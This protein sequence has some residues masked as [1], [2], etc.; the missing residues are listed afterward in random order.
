MKKSKSGEKAGEAAAC[1][2]AELAGLRSVLRDVGG[3]FMANLEA[4]IVQL[5][6][7]V[8]ELE[9]GLKDDRRI[10]QMISEIRDL[11]VKPGKGRLKDLKR[12]DTLVDRLEAI[13]RDLE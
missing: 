8:A 7:S 2:E 12:I 4:E 11:R 5:G 1:L 6:S 13:L 9:K 3:T 10:R